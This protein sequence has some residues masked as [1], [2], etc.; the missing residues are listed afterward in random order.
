M[1]AY[2]FVLLGTGVGDTLRPVMNPLVERS[3]V[4]SAAGYVPVSALLSIPCLLLGMF[5]IRH[6]G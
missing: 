6:L 5:A 1:I 4:L 2:L 3:A